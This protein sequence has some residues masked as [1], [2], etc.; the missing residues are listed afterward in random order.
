ME[1]NVVIEQDEAGVYVAT[2]PEIPGCHTQGRDVS[3][4]MERI[5]EAIEACLEVDGAVPMK[6]IGLRKIEISK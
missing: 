3:Q 1:F 2:V 5:K 6:F 4:V